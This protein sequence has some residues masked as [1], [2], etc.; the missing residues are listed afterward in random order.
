[1][2]LFVYF[3]LLEIIFKKYFLLSLVTGIFFFFKIFFFVYQ[4]YY[5]ALISILFINKIIKFKKYNIYKFLI[6][7]LSKFHENLSYIAAANYFR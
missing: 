5:I 3:A 4:Q 6:L 2:R 7:F 1:M